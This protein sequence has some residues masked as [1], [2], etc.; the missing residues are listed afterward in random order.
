VAFCNFLQK[1][2]LPIPDKRITPLSSPTSLLALFLV[3]VRRAARRPPCSR[4]SPCP[5]PMPPHFPARPR[6]ATFPP[7]LVSLLDLHA[8]SCT[9]ELAQ[10]SFF[11]DESAGACLGA[12][13]VLDLGAPLLDLHCGACGGDSLA[14]CTRGGGRRR[15]GW[16]RHARWGSWSSG[17]GRVGPWPR[18][19][20]ASAIASA[21]ACSCELHQQTPPRL[22]AIFLQAPSSPPHSIIVCC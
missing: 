22:L 2:A 18:T 8:P 17:C 5:T 12:K 7:R 1:S 9:S 19:R 10:D 21:T 14:S 6:Y 13:L 3:S 11:V 16:S 4:P 15:R 20:A